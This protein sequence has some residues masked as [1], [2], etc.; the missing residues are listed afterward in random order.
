[1]IGFFCVKSIRVTN[2]E[3]LAEVLLDVRILLSQLDTVNPTLIVALRV[4]FIL[5]MS[6][7]LLIENR[8]EKSV[9]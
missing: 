5:L 9:Q 3:L 2:V 1:L 8:D 4:R 7:P 6:P